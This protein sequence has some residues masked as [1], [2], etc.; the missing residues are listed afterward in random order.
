M[1]IIT[2][3]F[4]TGWMVLLTTGLF[5]QKSPALEYKKADPPILSFCFYPSTIRMINLKNDPEFN[6]MVRDIENIRLYRYG[7]KGLS[8]EKIR[9]AMR[10]L[11]D[12]GFEDVLLISGNQQN[13]HLMAHNDYKGRP[14]IFGYIKRPEDSYLIEIAGLFNIAQLPDLMARFQESD[15][16]NVLELPTFGF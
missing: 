4:L 14:V 1:P 12:K 11:M 6:E 3:I 15:F 2:R 13:T 5:A 10:H 9:S 8:T 16:I 7:E